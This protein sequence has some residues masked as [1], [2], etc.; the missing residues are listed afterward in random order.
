MNTEGA[1]HLARAV[2]T[3]LL[4]MAADHPGAVDVVWQL[5][6]KIFSSENPGETARRALV[7]TTSAEASEEILKRTLGRG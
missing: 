4:D 5:V 2:G 7:A 6:E 3:K 1:E